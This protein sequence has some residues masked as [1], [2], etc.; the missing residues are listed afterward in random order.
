MNSDD[1]SVLTSTLS[2][3]HEAMLY[4]VNTIAQAVISIEIAKVITCCSRHSC[5]HTSIF[6]RWEQYVFSSKKKDL[7]D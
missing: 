2:S 3:E 4:L 7:E 5:T 6:I 1:R